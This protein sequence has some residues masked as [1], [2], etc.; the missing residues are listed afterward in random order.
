MA[1]RLLAT[2]LPAAI[3]LAGCCAGPGGRGGPPGGAPM[4]DSG[5]GSRR[6]VSVRGGAGY[7][8]EQTER[9]L[10]E[11]AA[12][13]HLT[14]RQQLLWE[15]YQVRVGRLVA[16]QTRVDLNAPI[17]RGAPAE[18]DAK[19]DTVRNRLAAMEDIA[20]SAR[21]LYATL[22]DD[23]KAVADQRLAGTVPALYSGLVG[24]FEAGDRPERPERGAPGGP[25][26]MPPSRW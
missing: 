12:A 26:G 13:L 5:D 10:A 17:R 16:D 25:G 3:L 22:D 21:A 7:V 4:T 8:L 14:A 6:S 11:T 15:T 19:V 24:S 18:I 1:H 23:Q 9:Q 2:L 20:E